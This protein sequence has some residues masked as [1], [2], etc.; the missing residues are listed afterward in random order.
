[1]DEWFIKQIQPLLKGKRFIIRFADDFLLGFTNKEDAISVMK[2]LPNRFGKY[3]LTLHPDK[4][5][6]IELAER[7]RGKPRGFDFLGFTHYMENSRKGMPILK[8]KTSSRKFRAAVRRMDD[9]IR[10]NQHKKVGDVIK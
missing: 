6:L 8:R 7:E 5:K 3:G 10:D 9:W 1:L 4:T 2:M